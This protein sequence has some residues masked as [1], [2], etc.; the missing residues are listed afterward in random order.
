M[1]IRTFLSLIN[2]ATLLFTDT[3]R[4]FYYPNA[5][6]RLAADYQPYQA[7][8]QQILVTLEP[9][10]HLPFDLSIDFES[11]QALE[12]AKSVEESVGISETSPVSEH[13]NSLVSAWF[14]L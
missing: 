11:R 9:M 6:L 10:V 14:L 8:Y 2:N 5:F 12:R 4:K 1:T 13:S 3:L 7:L